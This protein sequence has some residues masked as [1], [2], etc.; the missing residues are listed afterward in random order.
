MHFRYCHQ[1]YS[2]NFGN[3][4]ENICGRVLYTNIAEWGALLKMDSNA[5]FLPWISWA[6]NLRTPS[7]TPPNKDV[8]MHTRPHSSYRRNRRFFYLF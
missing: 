1:N 3:F 2:E 4:H 8:E 6:P 5:E 7:F